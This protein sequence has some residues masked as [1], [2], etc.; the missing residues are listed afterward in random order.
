MCQPGWT[1]LLDRFTLS[2]GSL[3]PPW[4]HIL[5]D[6]L[7]RRIVFRTLGLR[8]SFDASQSVDFT[9]FESHVCLDLGAEFPFY[10][11]GPLCRPKTLL[12][13]ERLGYSRP[14]LGQ[15]RAE[16]STIPPIAPRFRPALVNIRVL[17]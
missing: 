12:V 16:V 5:L 7:D 15:P 3:L 13:G 11:T 8:K 10:I 2:R 14:S 6:S 1:L 17:S 4:L 9:G